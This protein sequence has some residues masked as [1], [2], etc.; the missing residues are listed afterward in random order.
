M[1][2]IRARE[3][4]RHLT[5]GTSTLYRHVKQHR[6]TLGDAVGE[7]AKGIYFTSQAI[8]KLKE[9]LGI[10]AGETQ[11]DSERPAGNTTDSQRDSVGIIE[12]VIRD[13]SRQIAALTDQVST[14]VDAASEERR[15]HD[16]IIMSLTQQIQN[17]TM[18]LEDLRHKVSPPPAPRKAA[19]V[20]IR[21]EAP[22][23]P[24]PAEQW[25]SL[26]RAW[27]SFFQPWKL[28][29]DYREKKAA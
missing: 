16:T 25:S 8:E 19:V 14:L 28:R 22:A 21:P 13:Q 2:K 17:Q 6:A 20:P 1:K 11:R 15:R 18:L 26:Q 10:P 27:V 9:I 5:I 7:D 29:R 3:A 4:A 24:H 12:N 23:E